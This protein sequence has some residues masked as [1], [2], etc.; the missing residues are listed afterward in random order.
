MTSGGSAVDAKLVL[1]RDYLY[2]IDI[3]KVSRAPIGIN[4]FARRG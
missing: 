4:G 3:E 2:I 1:D